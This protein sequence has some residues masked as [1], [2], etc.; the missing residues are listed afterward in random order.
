MKNWLLLLLFL[1][2][3]VVSGEK[4]SQK[5]PIFDAHSH[6]SLSDSF[7]YTPKQIAAKLN[8]NNIIGA[9]ITSTPTNRAEALY[10]QAPNLIIPFL[11]LY[12]TKA[13]KPNW[14]NDI[15]TL[16]DIEAQLEAFPYR[17]IGEFHIFK[18]DTYSP[19][20]EGVI[21]IAAKRNL[22]ILIH[23]DS[24]IIDRIF[25]LEPN[26]TVIWAHLGTQ[27]EHD[28]LSHM[29]T[30]Y[31]NNLYIDTSVRDRSFVDNKGK[32]KPEWKDFFI[33]H[34]DKMLAAVDTFSTQRWQRYPLALASIRLWLNQLPEPARQKIAYRNAQ[35]L[36]KK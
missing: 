18:K 9:V 25:E 34:Q 27:P 19:V 21:R 6:Y 3:L 11:S 28:F 23:G 33:Q 36:F 16:K 31:P 15:T 14:M 35:Q 4:N 20:L 1:P 32:L 29:L 12:K 30:C 26:L 22:T 13:N 8:Q 7:S 2:G 17:G 10:H 24:E 5:L